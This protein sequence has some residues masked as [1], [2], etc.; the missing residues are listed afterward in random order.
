MAMA[1]PAKTSDFMVCLFF[2]SANAAGRSNGIEK[3]CL[4][5]G[6]IYRMG[7]TSWLAVTFVSVKR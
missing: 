7:K 2:F 5:K 3:A 1:K 6:K 4:L